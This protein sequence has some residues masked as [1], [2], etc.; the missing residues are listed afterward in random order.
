MKEH[1]SDSLLVRLGSFTKKITHCLGKSKAPCHH[2]G[3]SPSLVLDSMSTHSFLSRLILPPVLCHI[4]QQSFATSYPGHFFSQDYSCDWPVAQ[5][6]QHDHIVRRN[7][8]NSIQS[9][10]VK[11]DQFLYC[12]DTSPP[13][14]CHIQQ[15]SLAASNPR[16]LPSHYLS[17]DW[18][19]AQWQ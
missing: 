4:Q 19:A 8:T 7:V 9:C 5:W 14:L 16:H 10:V 2:K 15:Q 1:L 6:H 3:V 17:C 18:P 11:P 12:S 13:V